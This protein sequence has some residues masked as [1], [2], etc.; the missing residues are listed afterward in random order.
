MYSLHLQSTTPKLL[1]THQKAPQSNPFIHSRHHGLGADG[2]LQAQRARR[3]PHLRR[4]RLSTRAKQGTEAAGP[5]LDQAEMQWNKKLRRD[6]S[7]RNLSREERKR[8]AQDDGDPRSAIMR[9]IEGMEQKEKAVK[10]GPCLTHLEG[11]VGHENEKVGEKRRV[12]DACNAGARL[13]AAGQGF[14]GE[15]GGAG[16]E[17]LENKGKKEAKHK[18]SSMEQ[19]WAVVW[20]AVEL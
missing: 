3:A 12:R 9:Q 14:R 5:N 2:G 4:R 18:L 19:E 20:Q 7:A 11:R 13:G 6:G 16:D 15:G 1:R 10:A 8:G 17:K